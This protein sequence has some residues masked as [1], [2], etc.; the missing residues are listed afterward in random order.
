MNDFEKR[1]KLRDN[2]K[3]NYFGENLKPNVDSFLK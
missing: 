2:L 1:R 3:G